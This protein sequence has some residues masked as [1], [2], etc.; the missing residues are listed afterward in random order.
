M[1]RAWPR[2]GSGGGAAC[3]YLCGASRDVAGRS[4]CRAD[5]DVEITDAQAVGKSWPEFFEVYRALGGSVIMR[6]A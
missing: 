2:R 1:R 6:D 3:V 5:G 4:A